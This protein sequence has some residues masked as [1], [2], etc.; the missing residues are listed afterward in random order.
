MHEPEPG[1]GVLT[2][3]RGMEHSRYLSNVHIRT[4]GWLRSPDNVAAGELLPRWEQRMQDEWGH[5]GVRITVESTLQLR[6]RSILFIGSSSP[7]GANIEWGLSY[8]SD[9]G[10]NWMRAP[11]DREVRRTEIL[12]L[13]RSVEDL[14]RRLPMPDEGVTA[15][16]SLF[17]SD[18]EHFRRRHGLTLC[19]GHGE[20]VIH[21][22]FTAIATRELDALVLFH[23][24]GSSER[25]PDG[26]TTAADPERPGR[27][28]EASRG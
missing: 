27:R 21:G 23:T 11:R 8:W 12:V 6:S 24:R 19:P 22:G 1:T 10:V 7:V 15:T 14:G 4:R 5:T 28:N 20:L 17:R 18:V 13:S 9:N 26:P 16:R 25:A 3:T 2:S